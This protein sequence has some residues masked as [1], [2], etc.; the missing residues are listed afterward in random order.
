MKQLL[1]LLTVIILTSCGQKAPTLEEEYEAL[2]EMNQAKIKMINCTI[3]EMSKGHDS[4][5]AC[6]ICESKLN[7]NE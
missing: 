6:I 5:T 7:Q 4:A 3:E 1:L 2:H